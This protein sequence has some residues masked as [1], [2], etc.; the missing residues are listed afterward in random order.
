MVAEIGQKTDL[1]AEFRQVLTAVESLEQ[2][3]GMGYVIDFLR[4][5]RTYGLREERHAQLPTF[6]SLKHRTQDHVRKLVNYL[7]REGYLLVLEDRYGRLG[8]SESGYTFLAEQPALGI[9]AK[10]LA[11]NALDTELR[12]QLRLLRKQFA[13]DDNLPPFRVFTDYSLQSLVDL[14]PLSVEEL[15]RV[16][17]F[18]HFKAN[19]YGPA[20]L[21]VIQQLDARKDTFR[22]EK[23][24]HK[25]STPSYQAI[26]TMFHSGLSLE[27][28]AERRNIQIGTVR[29]AL[30]CLHAAGEVDL[31]P[32]IERTLPEQ[33]FQ[34][35]T[36]YF[37]END[38]P[39]LRDAYEQ[40]GLDYDTLRLCKLY[41]ADNRQSSFTLDTSDLEQP[42]QLPHSAQAA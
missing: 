9:T 13:Q 10:A 15:L 23:Y 36:A 26:K 8:L 14:K 6:G 42:Q 34:T 27:E 4:G 12:R 3:F 2:R 35:G 40:L 22:R 29:S 28:M 11:E 19:R 30:F 37:A 18:G 20:L 39:L 33:D 24:L 32:W 1:G 5:G 21:R 31:K 7:L 17:G 41:I 25:A 38:N 16:P